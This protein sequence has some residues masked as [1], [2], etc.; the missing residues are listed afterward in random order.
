MERL[1]DTVTVE[2]LVATIAAMA[3]FAIFGQIQVSAGL[4]TLVNGLIH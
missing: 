4:V 2:G 1:T 3:I